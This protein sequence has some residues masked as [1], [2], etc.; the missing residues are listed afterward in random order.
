[1]RNTSPISG[2][3]LEVS[4]LRDEQTVR[5]PTGMFSYRQQ[6]L[7]ILGGPQFKRNRAD[8]VLKPFFHMLGGAA[9]YRTSVDSGGLSACAESLRVATCPSRFD[10]DRWTF[11]AVIGGG[12]DLR[13]TDRIDLRI[14]QV[15][16]TPLS[17]FGKTAHNLRFGVGFIFH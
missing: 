6:P 10:S 11:A 2:L 17:R 4:W 15:D 5:T 8:A 13:L 14:V 12:I 3:K 7:W 9:L 1:M 16:Y